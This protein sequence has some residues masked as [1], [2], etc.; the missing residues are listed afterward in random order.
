MK[1]FETHC[2]ILPFLH[3]MLLAVDSSVSLRYSGRG[4]SK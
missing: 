3:R 1:K 2:G 4:F